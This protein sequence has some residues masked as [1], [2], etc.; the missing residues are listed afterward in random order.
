MISFRPLMVALLIGSASA[1]SFGQTSETPDVSALIRQLSA[2]DFETRERASKALLLRGRSV[3]SALEAALETAELETRLR[4]EAIL[5]DLPVESEIRTTKLEPHRLEMQFSDAPLSEILE[6]LETA[7]PVRFRRPLGISEAQTLTLAFNNTPLL[8]ALDELAIALGSRWFRDYG[9]DL[10]RFT[11]NPGARPHC[12]YFG[13]LRVSFSGITR[14]R[15]LTFGLEAK[16]QAMLQGQI[17]LEPGSEVLGVWS[18]PALSAIRDDRERDLMPADVVPP[19]F[20]DARDRKSFH[21][22]LA[23]APPREDARSIKKLEGSFRLAVGTRYQRLSLNL[24]RGTRIREGKTEIGVVARQERGKE[25]LLVLE[26]KREAVAADDSATRT[27]FDDRIKLFDAKGV[28]IEPLSRPMIGTRS[29]A[30]TLTFRV[31]MSREVAGIEAFILQACRMET[32]DFSF[33]EIPLP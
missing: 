1:T 29:G 28:E 33:E 25:R 21:F 23:L 6:A 24:A 4:L 10:L 31:P 15:S 14:N 12:R 30:A 27:L 17:D 16:D 7:S 11:P 32:I 13:P 22:S 19:R 5:D 18:P 8:Q 20:H 26:L 2:T 9:T 3:R